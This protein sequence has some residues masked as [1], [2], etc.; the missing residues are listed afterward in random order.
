[1][2]TIR[3]LAE[4]SHTRGLFDEFRREVLA[5]DPCVSEEFLTLRRLQAETN[6]VDAV[7]QATRVSLTLN[8]GTNSM[9][10]EEWRGANIRSCGN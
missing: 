3:Y 8:M 5:I 9:T 6:F 10:P 7:P 2:R 1:M 4:G